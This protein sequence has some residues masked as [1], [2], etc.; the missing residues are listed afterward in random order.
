[1][2]KPFTVVVAI[3][4]VLA[5]LP[6]SQIFAKETTTPSYDPPSFTMEAVFI[7]SPVKL[8]IVVVVI[9]TPTPTPAPTP[10]PITPTI[11]E[12]PSRTVQNYTQQTVKVET[13][14]TSSNT[15]NLARSMVSEAWDSSQW[16]AFDR[17]ITMESGW[18]VNAEEPYSH[19]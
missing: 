7:P 17:I 3:I 2:N 5:P 18:R 19:A 6:P 8:S 1:M 12:L 11:R 15:K 16:P 10:K 4:S 9:P 13:V 14:D